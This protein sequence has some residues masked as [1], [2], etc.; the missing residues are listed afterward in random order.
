MK[1]QFKTESG[2]VA[3]IVALLIV[4]LVGM[5]ALVI[6][7]GSLYEVRR[8][9][10]TVADAAA[11]A[12]A[13]ELPHSV[14]EA[15]QKAI[16]YANNNLKYSDTEITE[17]N[18]EI[19]STEVPNDS[20]RVTPEDKNPQLFFSG[21]LGI[22]T[23]EVAATATATVYNPL[24]MN[25]LVPWSIPQDKYGEVI[26]GQSYSLKVPAQEQEDGN[27]QAM[28]FQNDNIAAKSGANL[29]EY[30]IVHGCTE[31]IIIGHQYP[32][33]PGN[34][35]GPTESG[36]ED[37][38]GGNTQSFSEVTSTIT[39][40]DGKTYYSG[41]DTTC[42]RIVL[43]PIIDSLPN[44]K[45][46]PVTIMGFAIFYVEDI[47]EEGKGKDKRAEVKGKFIDYML[48]QSTGD[49]TGYEGGLKVVR[50]VD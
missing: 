10:Q 36:V 1:K 30:N 11:L 3:V 9:L 42:P 8:N 6:D 47:S 45:S 24:S 40:D 26:P 34:M 33:E 16:E 2:Q 48:V 19:F 13:Q 50:L 25:H 4:S 22:N 12:G 28:C 41:T 35:V 49:V 18:I 7:V 29:Y 37:L 39:G 43:V 27:F 14:T 44:G 46:D 21:I 15:K 5:T 17:D 32:T 20:I 23:A 31:D 38:I